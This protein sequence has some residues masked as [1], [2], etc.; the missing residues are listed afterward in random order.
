MSSHRHT[1]AH[2]QHNIDGGLSIIE[3]APHRR[4]RSD[5]SPNAR[6]GTIT[7]SAGGWLVAGL[8][9]PEQPGEG[10][11]AD[12]PVAPSPPSANPAPHPRDEEFAAPP[13]EGPGG[14]APLDGAGLCRRSPARQGGAVLE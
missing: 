14:A 2:P 10:H 13:R 1:H 3:A 8:P 6:R 9:T 5:H 12:G 4:A 7:V 11:G